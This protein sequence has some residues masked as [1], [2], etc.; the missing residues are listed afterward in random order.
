MAPLEAPR[1]FLMLSLIAIV[2]IAGQL[3]FSTVLP[4]MASL[5]GANGL[6]A[7]LGLSNGHGMTIAPSEGIAIKR[8]DPSY[9]VRG[10]YQPDED[11]MPL[12]EPLPGLVLIYFLI[13]LTGLPLTLNLLMVVN[14]LVVA[15]GAVALASELMFRRFAL[16]VVSGIAVAAFVPL[17]RLSMTVG[18]DVYE[19]LFVLG[20]VVCL[21]KFRRTSSH[22]W[23]LANGLFLGMGLWIRSYFILYVIAQAIIIGILLFRSGRAPTST[24]KRVA[25][26]RT[27][28]VW[29]APILLLA[30]AMIL[31]RDSGSTGTALTR[32]GFWHSFWM[33]VGQFENDEIDGFTDWD[34]CELA[35]ELGY[36]VPCDPSY[37][38]P[39]LPYL[40]QYRTDYNAVLGSR[41][42]EWIPNNVF[43]VVRNTAIRLSWITVPGLMGSSKLEAHPAGRFLTVAVS[44]AIFLLTL[45]AVR[46][47]GVVQATPGSRPNVGLTGEDTLILV[48]TYIALIP[49]SPFYI[50]AKVVIVS[51]FCVL[52]TASSGALALWDRLR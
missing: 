49:L 37:T 3:F 45:F 39:G 43:R 50:I 33:G 17:Y 20:A 29:A 27:M 19:F 21:L 35:N 25:G 30:L 34:V 18:Y 12:I 1:R 51:Y 8:V 42:R 5:A 44:L 23:L 14:C 52:V 6:S 48:G 38:D 7:S 32:G 41:A 31:V 11:R 10:V 40:F 26:L 2:A 24:T 9:D 47:K 36:G 28:L 16:G 15:A 46:L 22:K 4:P 13:G